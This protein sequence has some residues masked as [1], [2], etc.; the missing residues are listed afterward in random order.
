MTFSNRE[1][2]SMVEFYKKDLV[3]KYGIPEI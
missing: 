3:P 1:M 2:K